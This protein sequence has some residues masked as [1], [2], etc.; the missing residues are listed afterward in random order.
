MHNN[1]HRIIVFLDRDGY[2]AYYE[3]FPYISAGGETEEEAL[4]ELSVAFKLA[5]DSEESSVKSN[6]FDLRHAAANG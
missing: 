1:C 3:E 2:T 5:S 4:R 6:R